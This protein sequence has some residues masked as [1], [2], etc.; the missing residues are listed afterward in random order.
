MKHR[1]PI[2]KGLGALFALFAMSSQ[3]QQVNQFPDYQ[4][5]QVATVQSPHQLPAPDF[6]DKGVLMYGATM[7]DDFGPL[8]FA[9]F[10]SHDANE[11][12]D[13][14]RIDPNDDGTHLRRLRL[15]TRCGD[16]YYGYLV[17]V[18]TYVEQVNKFVTVDFAT[19][20]MTTIREVTSSEEK[21]AWPTLYEMT[22]DNT[23]QKCYALGRNE[24]TVT[25]DIYE[26]DLTTGHYTKVHELNFYAWAMACDYEGQMYLVRGIPDKNDEFY[27][28]SQ[29]VLLD[30][31]N[32]YTELSQAELKDG[33][34]RFI[35]NYTHSMEFYHETNELY[36]LACN[37]S[38]FQY[39][40]KVDTTTAAMTR[41]STL[42]YNLVVGLYMP[43]DGADSRTAPSGVTNLSI[44]PVPYME[45]YGVKITWV[46]PSTTWKGDPLAG[47]LGNVLIARNSKDNIIQRCGQ[48]GNEGNE[49]FTTDYELEPG[50]NTYYITPCNDQGA[51]GITT[52]M[53][54]Y[55]GEDTPSQVSDITITPEGDHLHISWSKP[56]TGVHGNKIDESSLTYSV[57]RM[58]DSVVV[59]KNI[60]E[61]SVIDQNPG[62]YGEYSYEITPFTNRG[63]GTTAQSD[64]IMF[65]KPF[66]PTFTEDFATQAQ[67]DR[68]MSISN[69]GGEGFT[70]DKTFRRWFS[71]TLTSSSNDDWL[72][73]PP[74]Q[75][76]GGKTYRI[77]F[78]TELGH[79]DDSYSYSFCMG[80]EATVAGQ[81][82]VLATNENVSPSKYYEEKEEQVQAT[83]PSDG[84]YYFSM[85]HYT[86]SSFF[87]KY[88]AL[89]GF[90]IEEVLNKDLRSDGISGNPELVANTE[91][92]ITV[93]VTNV[94]SEP[95]S[96]YQVRVLDV[97]DET[98]VEIGTAPGVPVEPGSTVEI[99]IAVKAKS[100]GERLLSVAVTLEGDSSADNNQSEARAFHIQPEGTLSWNKIING[101]N[102]GVYTTMPMSFL[103]EFSTNEMVYRSSELGNKPATIHRIAFEYDDNSI[104]SETDMVEVKLYMALVSKDAQPTEPE[105]ST[106]VSPD[107][108]TLVYEGEKNVKPGKANK[109]EFT[110]STPF[111]YDGKHHLAIQVWKQGMVTSTTEMFPAMFKVF[112]HGGS[113]H[114][115][116]SYS[117]KSNPFDYTVETGF[118]T[119]PE[120]PVLHLAVEE[121]VGIVEHVVGSKAV[122]YDAASHQLQFDGVKELEI[123][124]ITGQRVM[125]Q[126][127]EGLTSLPVN[128]TTGFYVV[129]AILTEGGTAVVKILI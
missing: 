113:D 80:S 5:A 24:E 111:E 106:W 103:N 4:P 79:M 22:Y 81:S 15:G 123:I 8:H 125:L 29:L 99:P 63:E 16:Q 38:G 28:G 31:Q 129:R 53:R 20:E 68:W 52:S 57:V 62:N 7:Q 27:V 36:W 109:M 98:A 126:N 66:V 18:Y 60:P 51:R 26:I 128:L 55:F 35:P 78:R 110:L 34:N 47:E 1:N 91:A 97:T 10:Y 101:D 39:I 70:Y 33:S 19:G 44:T 45:D 58:P 37:N 120:I 21:E 23:H 11:L 86:P 54:I 3:A 87:G 30:P 83:I 43:F 25:S 48:W 49:T 75:L 67:A 72:I 64:K 116:L 14:A 82:T 112:N 127:V 61:T 85:H 46:N 32:G 69:N 102:E 76:Q 42:G 88:A 73:S 40:Y 12:I 96:D 117:S 9:K 107:D 100:E 65:G 71:Y 59:A 77:T 121:G 6:E 41:T 115:T 90:T 13:I 104:A 74:I 95:Q 122:R 84:T 89:Y 92:T 114:R 50:E 124:D 105:T 56:T 2:T 93:R 108:L 118:F 17:N 94:G 119:I